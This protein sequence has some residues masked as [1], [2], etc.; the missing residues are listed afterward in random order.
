MRWKSNGN[1][2]GPSAEG[3]CSHPSRQGVVVNSR[4]IVVTVSH[5]VK[6]LVDVPMVTA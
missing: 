2:E 5:V 1:R 4:L 3:G 6:V